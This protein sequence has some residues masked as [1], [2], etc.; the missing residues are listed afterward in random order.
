M[1]H[2]KRIVFFRNVTKMLRIAFFQQEVRWLHRTL[3]PPKN[4]GEK[5]NQLFIAN[6]MH[7]KTVAI[8]MDGGTAP[9]T[10]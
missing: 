8:N 9:M 4:K 5:I 7:I 1:L 10:P 3:I 6:Y 2:L